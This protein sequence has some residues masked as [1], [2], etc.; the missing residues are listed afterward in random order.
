MLEIS[1]YF[2]GAG[3]SAVMQWGRMG[4]L[5]LGCFALFPGAQA[6][7]LPD[8]NAPAA[9]MGTAG[10]AIDSLEGVEAVR[11]NPSLLALEVGMKGM[12]GLSQYREK[13]AGEIAG[14]RSAPLKKDTYAP[15]LGL[16]V[17][18]DNT[19]FGFGLLLDTPRQF[20]MVWPEGG[21]TGQIVSHR[22]TGAFGWRLLPD[23]ALGVSAGVER[24]SPDSNRVHGDFTAPFVTGAV[25]WLGNNDLRLTARYDQYLSTNLNG[26]KA[27]MGA[28]ATLGGGL[29]VTDFWRLHGQ[30]AQQKGG[31]DPWGGATLPMEQNRWGLA[32]VRHTNDLARLRLGFARSDT[33]TRGVVDPL[34][35]V[36]EREWHYAVGMRAPLRDVWIDAAYEYIFHDVS[37]DSA[38]SA[39]SGN[40][41]RFSVDMTWELN[42]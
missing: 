37:H 26:Q 19:D 24:I 38:G 17:T 29:W 39:F 13:R 9:I 42:P 2:G 34:M 35:P 22:L 23:V 32:L 16:T 6:A 4:G 30:I 10:I 11:Y 28:T 33:K 8:A 21:G 36:M 27:A 14:V 41:Y 31:D 3:V 25:T 15:E 5:L 18:P 7:V 12:L 20:K 1:Y 40:S